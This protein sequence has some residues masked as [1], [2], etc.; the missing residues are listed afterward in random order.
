MIGYALI[1]SLSYKIIPSD[2][3]K[4]RLR[5]AVFQNYLLE[6]QITFLQLLQPMLRTDP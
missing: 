4:T 3:K 6:N 1:M 5:K 2:L